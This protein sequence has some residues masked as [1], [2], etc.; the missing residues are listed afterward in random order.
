MRPTPRIAVYVAEPALAA[1]TALLAGGGPPGPRFGAP[2][3]GLRADERHRFLAGQ[4]AFAEA[5]TA[6]DGLGPVFTENT[7]GACHNEPALGGGNTRVET[8]LGRR[9][10]GAFDPLA[11]AGGPI[12]QDQGIGEGAG[13][14]GPY[15]YSREVVPPPALASSGSL[16]RAAATFW[17]SCAR[18]S[19]EAVRP[20]SHC[21]IA[22]RNPLVNSEFV[23]NWLDRCRRG[24]E[25]RIERR[26]VEL[27]VGQRRVHIVK[28]GEGRARTLGRHVFGLR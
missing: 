26:P 14:N 4:E 12:V 27:S 9:E 19:V 13:V 22:N 7:C 6:E 25:N 3:S 5:E 15:N 2:L 10:G 8:R 28:L 16:P 23:R 11:H 20:P 17:H 21:R 1:V 18:S 24:D